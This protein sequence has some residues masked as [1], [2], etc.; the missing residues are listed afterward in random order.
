MT[1]HGVYTLKEE[2]ASGA[3]SCLYTLNDPNY[4]IKLINPSHKASYDTFLT[5]KKI[6]NQLKRHP[7]LIY[8]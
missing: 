2:I 7:N 5:E 3:Y 8:C 1:K 4:V 6:Y